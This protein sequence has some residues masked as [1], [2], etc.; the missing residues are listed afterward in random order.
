ME[1]NHRR[2]LVFAIFDLSIS[3]LYSAALALIHIHTNSMLYIRVFS[4]KVDIYQAKPRQG[5][6]YIVYCWPV[7]FLMSSYNIKQSSCPCSWTVA[8]IIV[9][10]LFFIIIFQIYSI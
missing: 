8:S 1:D 10:I 2:A 7:S 3:F 5:H 6:T 9:I 4:L